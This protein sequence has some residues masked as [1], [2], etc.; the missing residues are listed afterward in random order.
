MPKGHKAALRW[1]YGLV[2]EPPTNRSAKEYL[3]LNLQKFYLLE[4]GILV[5]YLCPSSLDFTELLLDC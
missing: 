5:H 4:E 1:H 3:A 2:T